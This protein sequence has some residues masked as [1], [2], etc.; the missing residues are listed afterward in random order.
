MPTPCPGPCNTAY[1]KAAENEANLG[2]TYDISPNWGDPTQCWSCVDRTAGYLAKLPKLL[3]D[4][5]EEA[6]DGTQIKQT[7]T[8]GRAPEAT[9]PGQ[10]PRI[11]VDRI[12]SEMTELGADILKQRRPWAEA[13]TPGPGTAPNEEKRIE[14]IVQALINHW[15]WAMQNHPAASESYSRGNANPGGQATSW[16]FAAL[17]FTKQ[18]EAREPQR[19]APCPRCGGPWLFAAIDG[20]LVNGEPYIECSNRDCQNLLTPAEYADYRDSLN[21]KATGQPADADA[22]HIVAA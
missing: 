15:D 20:Q 12:V 8:I 19:L 6:T 9:W 16:Y 14:R 17:Y 4:V 22:E 3:K 2:I 18:D 10:A 5:L 11:L 13:L 1:R 21:R 7:G